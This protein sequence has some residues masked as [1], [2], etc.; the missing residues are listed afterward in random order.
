MSIINQEKKDQEKK[1]TNLINLTGESLNGID[2]AFYIKLWK[3]SGR[4]GALNI[5]NH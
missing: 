1:G 2:P 5:L 3:N 4:P